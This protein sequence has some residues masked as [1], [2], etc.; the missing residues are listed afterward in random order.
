MMKDVGKRAGF[1]LAETVLS[2]F[3]LSLVVILLVNL[4]PTS[5][6]TVRQG[7]N[8]FQAEQ[9]AAS[10]LARLQSESFDDLVVGSAQDLDPVFHESLR[11]D[12]R[13]E[14]FEVPPNSDEHLKG[15][16]VTVSWKERNEVR[17]VSQELYVVDIQK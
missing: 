11:F 17:Q 6:L 16:R 7:E 5:M 15:V 8:R 3:L 9:I 1:S 13:V 10:E 14:V 4:Y 2:I 12:R